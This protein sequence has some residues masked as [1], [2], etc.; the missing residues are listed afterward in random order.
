MTRMILSS[1][2]I[3]GLASTTAAPAFAESVESSVLVTTAPVTQGSIDRT[4]AAYGTIEAGPGASDVLAIAY[5]GIV[6]QVDVMPGAAVHRGQTIASV[7]IAPSTHAAYIQAEAALNAARQTL[8]HTKAL[9]AAHLATRTQLAQAEQ[10][11]ISAQSALDA[12]KRDGSGN[13]STLIA[14][15]YDG[16]V[17]AISVAPGAEVQPGT[18]IVT[19]LRANGLIATVGLDARQADRVKA[20]DNAAIT[21]ISGGGQRSSSGAVLTVA[22]MV[23]PK[24]GLIDATIS[25]DANHLRVGEPVA[26]TIDTGAVHGT[27]VPRDAALPDGSGYSVWQ[28]KSG[29]AV[30]VKVR[31]LAEAGNRSVITGPIDPSLPIVVAGNYQ[32]SPGIAVR[33]AH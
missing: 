30:A 20:G 2:L 7:G 18:A 19:I 16:I 15:P 21:P 10:A 3:L 1:V 24:S 22:S 25:I 6:R 26:V 17:T 13:A 23:N 27:I 5:A 28:V 14:A 12:L 4:V 9:L 33:V 32:L 8:A 31:I 11:K 29:H